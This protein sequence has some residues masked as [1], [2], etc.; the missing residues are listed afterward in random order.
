MLGFLGV[1]DPVSLPVVAK[2]FQTNKWGQLWLRFG[3]IVG[4]TRDLQVFSHNCTA[5]Q[6]DAGAP[7]FDLDTLDLIGMQIGGSTIAVE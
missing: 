1:P 4:Q 2:V 7:L 5:A 6:S 3:I